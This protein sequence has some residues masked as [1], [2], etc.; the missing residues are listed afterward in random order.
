[1]QPVVP[2]HREEDHAHAVLPRRR[3][4]EAELRALPGEER[5]RDLNQNPRPVSGLRIAATRSAVGEVD[6]DLNALDND[7]VG[8][9]AFDVRHEPDAAG[10]P[11]QPGIVQSLLWR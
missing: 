6:Q 8:F 2:L 5:V 7:L 9:A 11:F 3:Q 1:M 10:I 4:R